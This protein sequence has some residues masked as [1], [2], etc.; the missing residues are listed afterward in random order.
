MLPKPALAT[1]SHHLLLSSR[2]LS[3]SLFISPKQTNKRT[4]T[5]IKHNEQLSSCVPCSSTKARCVTRPAVVVVVNYCVLPFDHPN[6]PLFCLFPLLLSLCPQT[7]N[8]GEAA[9]LVTLLSTYKRTYGRGLRCVACVWGAFPCRS[10]RAH[11]HIVVTQNRNNMFSI[12]T[13][14]P[15]C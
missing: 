1:T 9:N 10:K 14:S 4:H 6:S 11:P 8:N 2:S 15:C 7:A 5:H 3:L 12:G 13:M